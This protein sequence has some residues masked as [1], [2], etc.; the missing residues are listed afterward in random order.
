MTRLLIDTGA[1]LAMMLTGDRHHPQAARFVRDQPHARFLL[2]NLVLAE[3]VTRLRARAGARPAAGAGR[4]LLESARYEVLFADESLIRGGLAR[5]EQFQDK[6]LS[7]TD[8][9]SFEVMDRFRLPAAFA[10][11]RDFRDCGYRMVP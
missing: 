10:F 4:K 7:L 8:C 2:T 1:L 5:L 3:V 6:R 9:V 11:D